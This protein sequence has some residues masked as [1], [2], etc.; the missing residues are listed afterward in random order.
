MNKEI[1]FLKAL[2]KKSSYNIKNLDLVE[3]CSCFYCFKIFNPNKIEEWTDNGQ[4]AICPYC[5]VDSILPM[6]IRLDILEQM[7]EH[8]FNGHEKI[9]GK[10]IILL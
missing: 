3:K 5:S 10:E 4:T 2:H 9:N 7:A 1:K 8:F 6:Q